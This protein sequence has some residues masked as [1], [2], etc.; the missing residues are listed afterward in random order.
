VAEAKVTSEPRGAIDR[1]EGLLDRLAAAISWVWLAL[2][3]VIGL[4]VILRYAFGQGRVELEELQWHLYAVGFLTGIVACVVHDRH[5]RVDVLRERMRPRTRD[6]VDFY[7]LLLFQLPL[8]ALVLWSAGAFVAES[9]Q[10]G[11]RSASPG[12][13]P[14]RWLLKAFLPLAFVALGAASLARLAR[15]ATRLFGQAN[16]DASPRANPDGRP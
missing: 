9:F 12:G 6:W 10:V 3:G 15:V 8:V 16:E 14:L 11:E 2:I 4:S 13:L 1:T 5:V 7:G